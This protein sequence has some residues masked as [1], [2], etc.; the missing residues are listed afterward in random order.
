MS[1]Q[2]CHIYLQRLMQSMSNLSYAFHATISGLEATGADESERFALEAVTD[3]IVASL[4]WKQALGFQKD[5]LS[6]SSLR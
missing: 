5:G 6:T 2:R 1:T 4:K 3:M